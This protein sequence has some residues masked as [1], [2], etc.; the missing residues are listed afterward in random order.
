VKWASISNAKVIVET[1]LEGFPLESSSGSHF[2]HNVISM[3]VGYFSVQHGIGRNKID[4]EKLKKHKP[5]N[6]T[7]FFKHIRFKEPLI[8]KMD[9]KK[10]IAMIKERKKAQKPNK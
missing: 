3:N 8:I 4:Y 5:L 2:F 1:N 7:K 6:K 9:G 10:G